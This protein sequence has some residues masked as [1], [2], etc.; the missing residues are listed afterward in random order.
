VVVT[1]GAAAATIARA[2]V[3]DARYGVQSSAPGV[4]LDASNL[5]VTEAGSYG[6]WVRAGTPTIDGL[7]TT[8]NGTAGVLLSDNGALTLIGCV[9]RNNSSYGAYFQPSSSRTLTLTNCSINANGTYGVFTSAGTAGTV[10][11]TSSIITNQSYGVY[12]NDSSSVSTT[13]SDVWNNTS[14]DFVGASAG[15]GCLATNPLYVST[16][17]LRLT[18]NSP[19]RFGAAGGGDMGALPYTTDPTPGLYGTLWSNRTLTAAASPHLVGG[20]LT[21]APGITLTVEPGATLQ[22]SANTDIM[23]AG[24]DTGR[25]ELLVAG[26]LLADGT[27]AAP[28][29]ML[30]SSTS[31][32]TWYGVD[33]LPSA[34]NVVIDQV[35]VQGQDGGTGCRCGICCPA[36]DCCCCGRVSGGGLAIR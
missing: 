6:L 10:T 17:D 4:V 31:S 3:Q 2:I 34:T 19:A 21:V 11:I 7:V 28:I 33:L 13:Y 29:A 5:T 35:I 16:V 32:G 30:S 20:D 1:A 9:L 25:G 24:S 18:A 22:F 14:G 15:L 23:R 27:L 26:T 12:R 8:A 36:G